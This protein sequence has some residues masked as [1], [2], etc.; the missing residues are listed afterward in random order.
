MLDVESNHDMEEDA[1]ID[2]IDVEDEADLRPKPRDNVY[3]IIPRQSEK[4][5]EVNSIFS[6]EIEW[7]KEQSVD[8]TPQN[9]P[10]QR[11]R[12]ES[13][14]YKESLIIKPSVDVDLTDIA[15]SVT[16]PEDSVSKKV[17]ENEEI[18]SL[19]KKDTSEEPKVELE[20]DFKVHAQKE[21]T[22]V[23][24]NHRPKLANLRSFWERENVGPKILVSR[25]NVPGKSEPP[26]T[27]D[28]STKPVES[29]NEQR[30]AEQSLGSPEHKR[31]ETISVV[32]VSDLKND[33]SI[34]KSRIPVVASES[35]ESFHS[36]QI[37][38]QT[39]PSSPS[40][41]RTSLPRLKSS[42]D[43]S[44]SDGQ[45]SE[46]MGGSDGD[47][48]S[49]KESE[50][51]SK[52]APRPNAAPLV[53]QNSQQQEIMAEKIKQLKS[54]W[55]KEKW[56]P[57]T[58]AQNTKPSVAS[59]K[60]NKRFTKSEFDLRSIGAEFDDDVEDDTSDRDKLSPN[61]SMYPLR[62]D[63]SMVTDG[64][65]TSQFKNL[66]DFWG[67]SPTS[68]QKSL[69]LK[70]GNTNQKLYNKNIVHESQTNSKQSLVESSPAKP[71]RTPHSSSKKKTTTRQ[72]SVSKTNQSHVA[73]SQTSTKD[74]TPHKPAIGQ[75]SRPQQSKS[76]IKGSLNGKAK[77][78]RRA[79]SMFSVNTAG[80]EQSQSSPPQSKE[81]PNPNLHQVKKATESNLP[82]SRKATETSHTLPKTSSE[83]SW[84]DKE[85]NSLRKPS[86]TSEDSD[87]QPLARSYIPPDYHHYLGITE[88]GRMYTAP[89]VTEQ[90]EDFLC[91]SFTTSPETSHRCKCSPVRTSTPVQGSPDLQRRGSLGLDGHVCD[92]ASKT[93]AADTW[94]HVKRNLN[95]KF[96][97][98]LH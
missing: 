43:G 29:K 35:K 61:F 18:D 96:K 87:F 46:R 10:K 54:F 32:E 25:S 70:S 7:G 55:E 85:R 11:R 57:R 66:R 36:N 80:E 8:K 60:L 48:T 19:T 39:L 84:R 98:F 62:K 94:S 97:Q 9:T 27:S 24:E 79:S 76:S 49:P 95:G 37:K 42:L 13:T 31:K 52:T 5:L 65:S 45:T 33:N 41:K 86:R 14:S 92:D 1:K 40:E 50:T 58:S 34:Q 56:E 78:M 15:N 6:E 88:T 77:A 51:K 16:Q 22:G 72:E 63:R 74:T 38:E 64:M 83:N 21:K 17:H 69:V 12:S 44:L 91:T 53:K 82:P 90:I 4:N 2:D 30:L 89:P 59:P 68:G 26:N 47:C 71:E 20:T 75:E 81:T 23:E 67:G 93:N 73:S 28:V 3:L